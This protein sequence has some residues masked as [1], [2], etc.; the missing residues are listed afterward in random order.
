MTFNAEGTE[1]R[2]SR[3]DLE[4]TIAN[5]EAREKAHKDRLAAAAEKRK[6]ETAGAPA[7]EKEEQEWKQKLLR[8]G[9][10]KDASEKAKNLA[11]VIG[12]QQW[13][14]LEKAIR[15][16]F[17]AGGYKTNKSGNTTQG[18]MF[19]P[20][21]VGYIGVLIDEGADLTAALRDLANMSTGKTWRE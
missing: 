20:R 8:A 14:N 1:Y 19:L 17:A 2:V 18:T 5:L 11:N 4:N 7:E 6:E 9:R 16:Y 21:L 15:E 3:A 10:A 13:K 12:S